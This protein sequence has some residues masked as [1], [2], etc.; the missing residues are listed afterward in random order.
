[1]GT[2]DPFSINADIW[3]GLL[4][5]SR[6]QVS[7]LQLPLQ[8]KLSGR[9]SSLVP[10]VIAEVTT[11]VVLPHWE[12]TAG[13][14]HIELNDARFDG[15]LAVDERGVSAALNYGTGWNTVAFQQE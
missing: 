12:T 15:N 6:Q 7:S 2:T 8:F 11:R 9:L 14:M 10:D 5:V 3:K 1:F 13:T 4:E